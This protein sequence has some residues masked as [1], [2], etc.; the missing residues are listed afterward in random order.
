MKS[1]ALFSFSPNGRQHH[2]NCSFKLRYPRTPHLH[3][4]PIVL[5]Y[6]PFFLQTVLN[7]DTLFLNL[8]MFHY[9]DCYGAYHNYGA[10][11]IDLVGRVLHTQ[12]QY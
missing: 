8:H 4:H 11:L 10:L 3:T 1:V 6:L 5:E 9:L 12:V 7:N 2:Y